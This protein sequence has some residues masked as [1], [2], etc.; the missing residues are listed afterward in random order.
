VRGKRIEALSKKYLVPHLPQF[1]ARRNL[2][3]L[4]TSHD[5]VRTIVFT[6]SSYS[7]ETIYASA[8]ICPLYVPFSTWNLLAP[9]IGYGWEIL[10]EN[11]ADEMASIRDAI[12][13][14]GLTHLARATDPRSLA[15]SAEA[16]SGYSMA[17]EPVVGA[18]VG[19]SLVRAGEPHRAREILAEAA[20]RMHAQLAPADAELWPRVRAEFDAVIEQID[21][22]DAA[23]AN[24]VLDSWL[25]RGRIRSSME[26]LF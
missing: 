14:E 24:R 19:Y 8:F 11:E 22:D 5:I 17:E 26:F 16:I 25:P 2:L 1:D 21:R 23:G 9:R 20:E 13:R 10:P 6:S 12:A 15:R 3:V 18:I 7:T 4:D